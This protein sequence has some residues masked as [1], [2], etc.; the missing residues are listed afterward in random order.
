MKHGYEEEYKMLLSKQQFDDLL[1]Y[2]PQAHFVSQTNYYYQVGQSSEKVSLRIRVKGNRF[3]F[4]LKVPTPH[5]LEEHEK[6]LPD[7]QFEKDE[8][9][10]S[11]LRERHYLPPYILWGSLNT[12][13]ALVPI[14]DPVSGIP[15]AE[16]CFD[17]NAYA[18]LVD[19]EIEYEVTHPHDAIASFT[20]ILRQANI[21]YEPNPL[22]KVQRCYLATHK[23]DDSQ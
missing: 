3:L 2:Y 8:E 20:A 1:A 14:S 7:M 9:I 13:R 12:K 6:E 22:A 21:C 4:T 19:Y 16:L 18:G 5:G 15:I 11:W 10:M 17:I 23:H